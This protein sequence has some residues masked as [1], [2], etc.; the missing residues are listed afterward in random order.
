MDV[1][2]LQA[3]NQ[4]VWYVLG[5]VHP[6]RS[7]ELLP[8]GKVSTDPSQSIGDE[9]KI[10]A[11]D[12]NNYGSDISVGSVPGSV[13]R[14]TFSIGSRFT[15]AKATLLDW[16][17]R[18]CRVDIY[19][20]SGKCGNPQ[21]F[22]EGGEKWMYFEDGRISSHSLENYGAYGRDENNPTNEMVDMTSNDYWEYLYERMAQI[23]SSS[24][25]Y[26][27]KTIDAY[28]GDMCETC[29]DPC[30]R[31]VMTM[32]GA[33][34]TPGTK[35][36]LLYSDDGGSTFG[37]QDISTM[38]SNEGISGA[39]I[40]GGNLVV[41]SPT[42]NSIHWTYLEDLFNGASNTWA[43]VITGFVAAKTPNAISSADV[44]HTW[45]VA[46][47]GYIYFADNIKVDVEV[48][49]AGIA[50]VQDLLDVHARDTE[51]VLAVG[52]SNA[53]VYTSNGGDT[54]EAVTGPAV[55]INLAACWMWDDEVWLVGE[56]AGGNG[57]LWLTVNAGISWTEVSLPATYTQIDRIKFISEAEGY[58]SARRGGVGYILRTITAGNEW[59]VLPQGKTGTSLDNDALN[60][61][62]VC[63]K[64][65]NNAYA[66][67][68]AGNATAGVAFK[69]SA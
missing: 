62:A 39:E 65:A 6:A 57:K 17:N 21:D 14:A 68:L 22:T 38:F 67:G 69:F 19:V 2:A 50:T 1:K 47:D 55:G 46:E 53:V 52:E 60:D 28:T 36:S 32:I 18:K 43:E 37:A 56:G 7:P 34:A 48:Q 13:E 4:R 59:V 15:A 20:L 41:I 27:I 5:G 24:T 64:Y 63:S 26:E 33:N 61:I 11:P 30:S 45:I 42:S 31:V 44:R 58:L 29:P 12:P 66:A 51:N 8:L 54:W 10:S 25:T 16:K 3:I 23:G 40:I 35:P 49:N 9:T